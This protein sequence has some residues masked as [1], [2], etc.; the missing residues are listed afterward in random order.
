M[1]QTFNDTEARFAARFASVAPIE[2]LRMS[3]AMFESAKRL[4]V[5]SVRHSEPALS[6]AEMR[7]RIFDRLYHDDFD[8][9][10]RV[11]LRSVLRAVNPAVSEQLRHPKQGDGFL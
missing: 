10:T 11:R 1:R 7:V 9:S 5:A 2:R 4:I 8:E 3:S 6:A